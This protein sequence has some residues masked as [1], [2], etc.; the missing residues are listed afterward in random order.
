MPA[1]WPFS[2]QSSNRNCSACARASFGT[3]MPPVFSFSHA[4]SLVWPDSLSPFILSPLLLGVT[5]TC[6]SAPLSCPKRPA[7]V[8]LVTRSLR[9]PPHHPAFVCESLLPHRMPLL[10]PCNI[11]LLHDSCPQNE[12]PLNPSCPAAAAPVWWRRPACHPPSARPV[13]WPQ[14]CALPPGPMHSFEPTTLF[15]PSC[16]TP[17]QLILSSKL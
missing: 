5:Q 1:V 7:P 3:P 6:L 9:V 11:F 10:S 8:R 2:R 13:P 16:S 4:P 14:F 15:P 12:N 17:I